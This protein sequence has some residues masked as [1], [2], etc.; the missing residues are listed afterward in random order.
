MLNSNDLNQFVH[1]A[2]NSFT[3][4]FILRHSGLKTL[5]DPLLQVPVILVYHKALLESQVTG[6]V[7][8]PSPKWRPKL[9][10][11]QC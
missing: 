3:N 10:I 8:D 5:Q 1:T 4:V 7:I 9:Q 2:S 11:G 6:V